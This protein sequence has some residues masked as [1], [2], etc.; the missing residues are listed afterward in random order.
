MEYA[1]K[2]DE[3]YMHTEVASQDVYVPDLPDTTPASVKKLIR[4]L[5]YFQTKRKSLSDTDDLFNN[6]FDSL[7]TTQLAS[8]LFFTLRNRVHGIRIGPRMIY[9][10]PSIEKLSGAVQAILDP[11]TINDHSG[12]TGASRGAAMKTMVEKL[13]HSLPLKAEGRKP[14]VNGLMNVL[15]TGTTGFLGYY[16]LETLLA[17]PKIGK[18]YCINRASD[19]GEKFFRRFS[20][21]SDRIEFIQV[22]FGQ[23]AFGLLTGTFVRMV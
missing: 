10:N 11:D 16:L 2:I 3:L 13:S 19:A 18:I 8:K 5:V 20:G 1:D 17:D 9:E 15:V 7:K 14:A 6:G 4:E 21:T 23:P 22:Q 12:D